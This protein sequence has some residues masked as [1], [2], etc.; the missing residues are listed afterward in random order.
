MMAL[1]C[2]SLCLAL[3]RLLIAASEALGV[4]AHLVRLVEGGF[5]VYVVAVELRSSFHQFAWKGYRPR[6]AREPRQQ[7][8]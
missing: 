5:A 7:N 4:F 6:H 2:K 1:G 3:V 8:D